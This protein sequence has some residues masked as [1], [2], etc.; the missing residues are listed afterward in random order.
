M[1]SIVVV[2]AA[3]VMM[4]SQHCLQSWVQ[5]CPVQIPFACRV[6]LCQLL[7]TAWTSDH[8]KVS[9]VHLELPHPHR[10]PWGPG[11]LHSLPAPAWPSVAKTD[12]GG[13]RKA[14]LLHL[15]AG[16]TVSYKYALELQ[17]T[18]RRLG[19]CGTFQPCSASSPFL[20]SDPLT[21]SLDSTSL[22]RSLVQESLLQPTAE[23]TVFHLHKTFDVMFPFYRCGN[24]G[25][26]R[27]RDFLKFTR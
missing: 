21:I 25:S 5:S 4:F 20:P 15:N 1:L 2:V 9:S 16:Q 13:T 12:W 3:I 17:G 6:L 24:G 7:P 26:E 27:P 8:Q 22:N 19:I 18:S 14:Q 10:E 11:S 23:S